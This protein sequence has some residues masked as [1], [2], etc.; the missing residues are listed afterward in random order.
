M[1][2]RCIP[3]CSFTCFW[4][5]C[6]NLSDL[7]HQIYVWSKRIEILFYLH[8]IS[9]CSFPPSSTSLHLPS[10]STSFRSSLIFLFHLIFIFCSLFLPSPLSFLSSPVFYFFLSFSSCIISSSI[11]ILLPVLHILLPPSNRPRSRPFCPDQHD[12]AFRVSV[13]VN[14]FLH[15]FIFSSYIFSLIFCMAA[16]SVTLMRHPTQRTRVQG[17]SRTSWTDGRQNSVPYTDFF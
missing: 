1:R 2:H 16:A 4:N 6:L 12:C 7:S 8:L 17:L 15:S 14:F 5:I 3:V 13:R 10:P 11:V 9:P